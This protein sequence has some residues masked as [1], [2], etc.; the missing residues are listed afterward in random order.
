VNKSKPLFGLITTLA[1]CALLQPVYMAFEQQLAGG[2]INPVL[3]DV[4]NVEESMLSPTF[5]SSKHKNNNEKILSQQQINNYNKQFFKTSSLMTEFSEFPETLGFNEISAK[6]HA[7]SKVPKSKR[8]YSSGKKITEED[9]QDYQSA[10]NLAAIPKQNNIRFAMVVRRTDM[11]TFPTDDK[12]YKTSTNKNIDRFQETALFPTQVVALLHQSQDKKWYFGVSYN[13]AAWFKKSDVAIGSREEIL[14][15]KNRVNFLVVTGSKV[16]TTYNPDNKNI[17]EVQLEM[18]T[19]IPVENASDIPVVIGGQN[20]YS[21]HVVSLPTRNESG[22]LHFQQALIQ[23]NQDVHKGFL[24]YTRENIITQ[25]F[26]FLGERYGWGHSFNARDCTGF[27]G[28]VFKTFGILMPRNSGEQGNSK[29][30]INTRFMATTSNS[31]KLNIINTLEVGDLI[32]R[33]GHVMMFLG[34]NNETPYIIHDVSDLKYFKSNG[35]YYSGHLNAV[36]IT[37][38]IPLHLSRE[39]SYLDKLYNIKKIK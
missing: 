5:W 39:T 24:P 2:S 16:F 27:V 21:S 18:G 30:G 26:K 35:E 11:R 22:A 34:L 28:E 19:V 4:I 8:F 29:Q 10:I 32:Y 14:N 37:P 36:S 17:S 33:P 9:Y 12:V 38:L 20:T 15:Y 31:E 13:Y 25:S 3:S 1:I 7:I 23:K 6:I